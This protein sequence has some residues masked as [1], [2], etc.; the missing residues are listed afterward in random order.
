MMAFS[1]RVR[2]WLVIALAVVAA[3][4]AR[5]LIHRNAAGE[6]NEQAFE[7]LFVSG[8]PHLY[9]E[10]LD[11][12]GCRLTPYEQSAAQHALFLDAFRRRL[13]L[14]NSEDVPCPIS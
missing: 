12:K 5:R 9:T 8:M 1:T 13:D 3:A 2:E 7:T 10:I 4:E 14:S 11:G 6:D